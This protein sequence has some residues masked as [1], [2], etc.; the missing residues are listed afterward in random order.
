MTDKNIQRYIE[1]LRAF[2][3]NAIP[4]REFERSFLELF[5]SD[6]TVFAEDVFTIL[7]ELFGN[8]DAF[9]ADPLLRGEDDL[10][11]DQL[12]ACS[13]EALHKLKSYS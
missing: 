3:S 10:D 5:K 13:A 7:D 9:C 11:E 6:E 2:V 1:L 12:R 4:A 8:V